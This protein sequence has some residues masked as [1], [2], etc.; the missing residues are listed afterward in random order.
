[1]EIRIGGRGGRE[2]RQGESRAWRGV[3]EMRQRRPRSEGS[4]GER[5]R[6]WTRAGWQ[7]TGGRR[8]RDTGERD[9]DRERNKRVRG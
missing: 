4:A 7:E 6:E 8:G 3:G 2:E 1:M 5:M 9:G